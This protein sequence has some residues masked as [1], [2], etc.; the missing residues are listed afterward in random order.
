VISYLKYSTAQLKALNAFSE[1][2]VGNY[3]DAHNSLA[4]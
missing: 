1:K 4:K 2:S 3:D